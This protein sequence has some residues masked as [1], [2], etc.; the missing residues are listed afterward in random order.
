LYQQYELLA[1]ELTFVPAVQFIGK[2]DI[3]QHLKKETRLPENRALA[4]HLMR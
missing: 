1:Q 2:A 3:N 4:E